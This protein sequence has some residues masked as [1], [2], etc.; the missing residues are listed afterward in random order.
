M[1]TRKGAHAMLWRY[2]RTSAR[3]SFSRQMFSTLRSVAPNSSDDL[4][5]VQLEDGFS[6]WDEHQPVIHDC[7]VD[8]PIRLHSLKTESFLIS[9]YYDENNFPRNPSFARDFPSLSNWHGEIIVVFLGRRRFFK[10][11]ARLCQ[12]RKAVTKYTSSLMLP[13]IQL[14]ARL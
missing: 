7:I 3:L 8:V 5:Y 14:T 10:K 2:P 9:A 1:R 4:P 12:V 6:R 13:V 11:N